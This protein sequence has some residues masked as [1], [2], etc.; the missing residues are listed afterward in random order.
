[1]NLMAFDL[2]SSCEIEGLK[3]AI[4]LNKLLDYVIV[5]TQK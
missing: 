5:N 2:I 4:Y 3:K 1:M